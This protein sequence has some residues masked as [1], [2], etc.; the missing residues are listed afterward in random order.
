VGAS[1]GGAAVRVRQLLAELAEARRTAAAAVRQASQGSL[2]DLLDAA[3]TVETPDGTVKI[4]ATEVP[5][6]SA[7]T[8][9]RLREV[10]DWLRDKLA[11]PSVL[12]LASVPQGR[13]PQLL[14]AVSKDL[15]ARGAHAGKL[16]SEVGRA[17][18]ARA[19]GRPEM[20]QGGGGDPARLSAALARGREVAHQQVGAAGGR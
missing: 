18:D 17:M 5:A 7:P 19:G 16:L 14:A 9:E 10:S 8:V 1:R 12:V 2:E 4:L 13:P 6:A 3:E 15:A 20:A 11:R